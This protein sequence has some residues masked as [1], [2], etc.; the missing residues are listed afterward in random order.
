MADIHP[1]AILG[2]R[3]E[4]GEGVVIGPHAI[5]ESE[6]AIG[7][8]TSV[9]PRAFIG[10]LVEIGP[11]CEVGLG[12][13]IG[14]D[15]QILGW[16]RADSQVVIGSHSVIREYVTIHRAKFAGD[17]TVIG[18]HCFL[19]GLSHVAHDCCIGDHVVIC[20]GTLLGGHVEVGDQA[21][22]SG[23]CAIH[24]HCRIGR[25]AMIQGITAASKDVAPFTT[26]DQLNIARGLN[27]VGLRRAGISTAARREL[28]I[29]FREIFRTTRPVSHSLEMIES[30]PMCDEVREMVEFMR[31]TKRGVSLAARSADGGGEAEG[32]EE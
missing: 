28:K 25:L 24:Q 29:A 16:E 18:N 15:P 11:D 13:Q 1:T 5:I 2:D 22:I 19:M 3:V 10:R 4:L 21:F 30:R 32:G 12:A 17:A 6:V 7:P 23:N 27:S 26:V 31:A 9:G 14:G 20:N 8:R